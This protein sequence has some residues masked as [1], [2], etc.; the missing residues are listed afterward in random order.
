VR[1]NGWGVLRG[2]VRGGGGGDGRGG[3]GGCFGGC[4]G[5]RGRFREV[6]VKKGAERVIKFH[7]GHKKDGQ[8]KR[9]TANTN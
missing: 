7:N 5:I 1:G 2:G 4:G 8:S 3:G 9:F 6:K